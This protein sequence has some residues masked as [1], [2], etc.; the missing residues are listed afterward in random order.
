MTSFREYLAWLN[1]RECRRPRQHRARRSSEFIILNALA[2]RGRLFALTPRAERDEIFPCRTRFLSGKSPPLSI[3]NGA[4]D[5]IVDWFLRHS[6][7]APEH[8]PRLS[9]LRMP[10][11]RCRALCRRAPSPSAWHDVE[12]ASLASHTIAAAPAGARRQSARHYFSPRARRRTPGQLSLECSKSAML[13]RRHD[14]P[15]RPAAATPS[16]LLSSRLAS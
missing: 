7:T 16:A 10:S 9:P 1:R 11:P 6:L 5:D 3:F 15:S 8:A 4:I 12:A 14:S 2:A 13:P